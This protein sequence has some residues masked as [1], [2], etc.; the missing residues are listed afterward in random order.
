MKQAYIAIALRTR[1]SMQAEI[2]AICTALETAR[3]SP[4]VFVDRYH[5]AP[6]EA[7]KMMQIAKK[8]LDES[9]ILIAEISHKAIGVG[10]E[11][12]Y[13]AAQA[14]TII[15]LRHEGADYSSTAGGLANFEIVYQTAGDLEEKLT[16][17]FHKWE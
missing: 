13:M 3:I 14:K 1:Q 16:A 10:I 6:G 9:A 15:Y 2:D 11:I 7:V 8:H 17:F 4:F 5:F 12:G